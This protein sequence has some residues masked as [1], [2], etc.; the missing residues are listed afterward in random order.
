MSSAHLHSL[1]PFNVANV[2]ANVTFIQCDEPNQIG[3]WARR[4]I[5][6][7]VMRTSWRKRKRTTIPSLP[8]TDKTHLR[9][10]DTFKPI[11]SMAL[12]DYLFA[13]QHKRGFNEPLSEEDMQ[14]KPAVE[15]LSLPINMMV[16]QQ[17]LDSSI[18]SDMSI[19]I[20]VST[21]DIESIG[22]TNTQRRTRSHGP[23]G[24]LSD[25]VDPFASIIVPMDMRM[26]SYLQYCTSFEEE[27]IRS[28]DVPSVRVR[29]KS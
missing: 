9:P 15:C 25:G 2:D 29:P 20:V 8:A 5:R 22:A 12:P 19:D 4:Q 14:T 18:S 6:I 28:T 13:M 10:F 24:I 11:D 3:L 16:H 1:P 27:L 23:F 26:H 17:L 7:Q 21:K